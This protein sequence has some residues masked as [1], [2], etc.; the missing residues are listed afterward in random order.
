MNTTLAQ[1]LKLDDPLELHSLWYKYKKAVW[2]RQTPESATIHNTMR[3]LRSIR[4]GGP[5]AYIS[6]PITSGLK[7]YELKLDNPEMDK[8]LLMQEVI[9]YNYHMGWSQVEKVASRRRCSVLYPADLVP[10]RQKWQQE[11]FQA[12]W[13]SIIAEFCTEIHMCDGWNFSNGGIEE[14]IHVFQLKL[15]EPHSGSLSSPFY[16]TK[17]DHEQELDR[18]RNIAVFDH[19]GSPISIATALLH[20]EEAAMWLKQHGFKVEHHE[21]CLEVLHWTSEMIKIGFYQKI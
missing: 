11:D 2:G 18:M 20:I 8:K 12:L 3:T 19:E 4:H 10:A 14:L 1:T 16:N 13:L 21:R 7:Y 5:L 15:G 6:V 9:S 17:G